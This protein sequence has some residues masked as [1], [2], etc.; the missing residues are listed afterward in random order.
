MI[1]SIGGR[2]VIKK[3]K[4]ERNKR[5]EN[6][7]AALIERFDAHFT[8]TSRGIGGGHMQSRADGKIS[9]ISLDMDGWLLAGGRRAPLA[10]Q[11]PAKLQ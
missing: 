10:N 7:S 3:K 5:L 2:K 9:I 4:S 8:S 6:K 11:R 1:I